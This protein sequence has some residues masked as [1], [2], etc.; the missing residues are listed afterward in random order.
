MSS[1]G[2]VLYVLLLL[3][4]AF[5]LLRLIAQRNVLNQLQKELDTLGSAWE[6]ERD[7]LSGFIS[8]KTNPVITI[9]IL[10][11]VEVAANNSTLGGMIGKYAPDM[12]RNSVIKRTAKSMRDEMTSHGMQVEV[13]VHGIN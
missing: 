7:D 12:I 2:I 13:I 4:V 11:A 10:N 8:N 3:V 9:E 6:F 5:L 1:T